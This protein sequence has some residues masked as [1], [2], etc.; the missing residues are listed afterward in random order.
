M[1]QKTDNNQNNFYELFKEIL[2]TQ[3]TIIKNQADIKAEIKA[4][5][6]NR[7]SDLAKAWGDI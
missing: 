5:A 7:E 3:N 4:L 2:E 6:K 1:A